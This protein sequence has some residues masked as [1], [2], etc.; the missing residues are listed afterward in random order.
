MSAPVIDP[1]ARLERWSQMLWARIRSATLDGTDPCAHE[2]EHLAL[3]DA[4]SQL[5]GARMVLDGDALE[6]AE[7]LYDLAW[8][9]I[10]ANYHSRR[11]SQAHHDDYRKQQE[12][13]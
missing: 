8:C 4:L 3:A 2:R 7:T 9:R 12:P 5:H 10:V 13:A 11:L 1:L 6:A